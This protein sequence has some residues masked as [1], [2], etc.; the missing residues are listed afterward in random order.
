[1]SWLLQSLTRAFAIVLVTGCSIAF[2]QY[3]QQDL[4][5]PALRE[6]PAV[7]D[8]ASPKDTSKKAEQKWDVSAKHGPSTD[9]EFDTDEG[10]WMAC[11]VSPDGKKIVFDLLGD[12]YIMPYTGGAA[13]LLS[14]GPS[15]EAQPRFSPDGTKIS[16]TSDRDGTDNIWIMDVSGKNPKQ[17][18]KEKERQTNNA[19]W[20]HD[21]RTIVARK[22]YRNTR[23]LGAGEMWMYFVG[24]GD[25]LQLTKRRNWEQDAGEPCLSPDGRYLYYSED[26][27]PGGGFQY[28]KDPNGVIYVIQRLDLQTGK[29]DQF[30]NGQGGSARPQV[31]PDG[32]TIAFVKR[33][34]LKTVLYL[35]DV[36]SGKET[37]VWDNLNRDAQET[38]AMFGVHP[39]FSWTPDGKTI[40]ISA[41]G[42]LWRVNIATREAIQIPFSV[43][44]KQT[45]TDAVRFPQ[46]VAPEKFDVKMLRFVTVSPDQKSVIYTALGKLYSKK[47]PNGPPKRITSD[48][49]N[50]EL[51]PSFS[52]DGKWIVYATW[53][54]EARGAICKVRPDGG[55][56]TRLT[57]RTGH[58]IS[59]AFSSDGMKIVYQRV[60]GDNIRGNTFSKDQGIYWIPSAGGKGE[61]ITEEGS[62]PIFNTTGDRIFLSS[63]EGDKTALISVGLHGELRRVHLVSDNAVEITRSPDE[64]WV[65]I[66]ERF[67]TYIAAFPK[68][69]QA[70]SIG[71]STGDYPIKRVTRDAG[72]YLNWSSDSKKLYW[73]LGPE[74]F[75]RDLTNTFK[76]VE[77]ARDSIQEK[78]DTSG[79]YIGFSAQTD[80][81][82]GTIALV[83]AT[84]ISMKGDEVI[85]DATI[86][87][88]RNRIISVGPSGSIT[89]PS[90]A[91]KLDVRGKFI[92]PGIIDVHAHIG[93][94]SN[95]I[96]AQTHW[97]YDVNLA[98]GVTTAHDP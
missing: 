30:I 6:S 72:E 33:V 8:S 89:V 96:T 47:L 84:V 62:N 82:T 26:V 64:R 28:N 97:P 53:N 65:A 88:E 16:F 61:L 1:M 41:K 48:E 13:T 73:S 22:H 35:Y 20:S 67:N 34:R 94:G 60:G 18:T 74:L 54:D 11:D 81:P 10:T 92:M 71:P 42:H 38:W 50:F 5:E 90:A 77:G 40:V 59:P 76:F 17:I 57:T 78:P 32:K 55:S 4:D 25:G 27:S 39:G 3:P 85:R 95:G 87:I 29:T 44:V 2:A 12:I 75:S 98:F 31:S 83:G 91:Y 43:H 70:V 56:M 21:G 24:G 52:A 14:G 15:Y 86:L 9:V 63:N 37:P 51:F 66:V 7:P 45:I 79:T 19:V 23:S 46:E 36:E 68:T 80:N 93:T 69:G 49:K 58:Y